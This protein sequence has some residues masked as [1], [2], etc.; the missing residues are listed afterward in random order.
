M[1]YISDPIARITMQTGIP[2]EPAP[3][4][5][6]SEF[7]GMDA[8][9]AVVGRHSPTEIIDGQVRLHPLSSV[10]EEN[11]DP[12]PGCFAA[13]FGYWTIAT[14]YCGE[15]Y[16]AVAIADHADRRVVLLSHA[17][18]DEDTTEA[19]FARIAKPI[20]VS[21]AGFLEQFLRDALDE[22]CIY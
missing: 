13:A 5:L 18:V 15:A 9:P 4:D 17:A 2:F 16:C 12:L 3:A 20:A 22:E 21:L 11:R 8:P 14:S 1:S 7:V 19:E 10:L 6:L